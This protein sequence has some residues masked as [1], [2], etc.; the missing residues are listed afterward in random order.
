M[1]QIFFISPN[2]ASD[3]R[4]ALATLG[5]AVGCQPHGWRPDPAQGQV[6]GVVNVHNGDPELVANALEDAGITVLPDHKQGAKIA[7]AHA[8]KLAAHGV[9]ASDTTLSAMTKVHAIAG[10]PPIKPRRF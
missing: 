1:I 4:D 7:A 6:I 8:Q 5:G 2:G 3:V 9:N 10:F